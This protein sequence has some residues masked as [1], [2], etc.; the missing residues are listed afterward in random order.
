MAH[1]KF[2]DSELEKQ[3]GDIMLRFDFQKVLDHMIATDHKWYMGNNITRVPDMEDIRVIARDLLTK[4]AYDGSTTAN[5]GTGG[6]MAYKLSWGMSL[7]F[8]LS[9]S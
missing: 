5:V 6:F 3:N 1:E 9:W 8:Q 7:T 2:S 4:A